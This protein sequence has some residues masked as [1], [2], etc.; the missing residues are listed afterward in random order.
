MRAYARACVRERGHGR[1]RERVRARSCACARA[2]ARLLSSSPFAICSWTACLMCGLFF[3]CLSAWRAHRDVF[4]CLSRIRS[5]TRSTSRLSASA[6]AVR[7]SSPPIV[8]ACTRARGTERENAQTQQRVRHLKLIHVNEVRVLTENVSKGGGGSKPGMVRAAQDVVH[9]NV[10]ARMSARA[11]LL[12]AHLARL[13]VHLPVCLGLDLGDALRLELVVEE[14]VAHLL[15][16]GHPL[17][18]V[19]LGPRPPTAPP[20]PPTALV[21]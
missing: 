2:R 3:C 19:G 12:G 9:S 17:L 11:H 16:L 1:M 10:F 5:C 18:D 4:L 8:S 7:L 21:R 14:Q 20:P 13:L 15:Q 6:C